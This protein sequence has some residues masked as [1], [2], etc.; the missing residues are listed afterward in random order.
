DRQVRGVGVGIPDRVV[1]IDR[2]RIDHHWQ[3]F[4][5]SERDADDTRAK[6]TDERIDRRLTI[7][8]LTVE[9]LE[10]DPVTGELVAVEAPARPDESE[11]AAGPTGWRRDNGVSE[12]LFVERHIAMEAEPADFRIG[13][14][15]SLALRAGGASRQCQR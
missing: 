4:V 3:P 7:P 12:L 14:A 13:R 1:A 15:A 5:D 6:R 9:D 11:H 8:V 10:A 2:Q